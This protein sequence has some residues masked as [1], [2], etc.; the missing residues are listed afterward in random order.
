MKSIKL[1]LLKISLLVILLCGAILTSVFAW[2]SSKQNTISTKINGSIV[3]EYFH[4]GRGT[5]DNPFII[6]RPI[7]YYHMVEF[8]QR[9]TNLDIGDNEKASFGKEYLYFQIGCPLAQLADP[10][11]TNDPVDENDWYV[12]DYSNIGSVNESTG[13]G[14]VVPGTNILASKTLNMAYFSGERALMPIGS[15]QVPFLGSINGH[16][17]TI[18]NLHIVSH[19]IVNVVDEHGVV[20]SNVSR[21]TADMGV[22]GCVAQGLDVNGD[23]KIES[24]LKTDDNGLEED[25]IETSSIKNMYITNATIDLDSTA[26]T[27]EIVGELPTLPDG[28]PTHSNSYHTVDENGEVAETGTE[29]AYVGYIAGHVSSTDDIT[30]V[31]VNNCKIVG[32]SR[33]ISGYGYF[34]IIIDP[35]TNE[36]VSSLGSQIANIYTQ[37]EGSGFGGSIGMTD[38]FER[39]ANIRSMSSNIRNIT[40]E[41]VIVDEVE[42]KTTRIATAYAGADAYNPTD[43]TEKIQ[44]YYSPE[45]GLYYLY[46]RGSMTKGYNYLYG[47][48]N[49]QQTKTVTTITYP[50]D[51][52]TGTYVTTD[53]YKIYEGTSNYLGV[54][55][56]NSFIKTTNSNAVTLAFDNDNHL[57]FIGKDSYEQRYDYPYNENDNG[58]SYVDTIYYL[59]A[60]NNYMS[61]GA[62]TSQNASTW[63]FDTSNRLYT[64]N[65]NTRYYLDY[66]NNQWY[67]TPASSFYLFKDEEG[68]YLSLSG[69]SLTN[70]YSEEEA[71]KFEIVNP[72]SSTTI[73]KIIN[74]SRYY[75]R[76]N[77]GTLD[78]N[79]TA[80]NNTWSYDS[81]NQTYYMTI[82]STRYYLVCYNDNWVLR[83]DGYIYQISDSGNYLNATSTTSF[84]NETDSSLASFWNLDSDAESTTIYT[85]FNGTVTYLGVNNGNLALNPSYSSYNWYRDENAYYTT[86]NGERFYLG[87]EDGVWKIGINGYK[88][89]TGINYLNASSTTSTNNVTSGEENAST[90]IFDPNANTTQFY[91]FY[92]GTKVYLG[93]NGY[94]LTVST[95]PTTWTKEDGR[96]YI[97][98]DGDK[99]YLVFKNNSW[100]LENSG[101]K[102]YSGY[103]YLNASSTTTVSNITTG[104]QNAST[105]IFDP[106]ANSTEI[107]TFSNGTKV[108]LGRNGNSLAVSTTPTTW[109]N[110][111]GKYYITIAGIIFYLTFKN[112]TWVLENN[113]FHI[114]DGSTNYLSASSA[115]QFT[116]SNL[117]N[118]NIWI[119]DNNVSSTTISTVVNGTR[120]YL[121]INGYSLALNSSYSTTLWTKDG[122]D[123]YALSND[124]VKLYLTYTNS[125][126]TVVYDTVKIS[127]GSNYLRAR[128]NYNYPDNQANAAN[129]TNFI[130][131]RN[132]E[133]TTISFLYNNTTRYYLGIDEDTA[134]ILAVGTKYSDVLWKK[135]GNLYYTTYNGIDYYI[136]YSYGNWRV[137]PKEYVRF[138]NN[139]LSMYIYS[140]SRTRNTD[141]PTTTANFYFDSVGRCYGFYS[142]AKYYIRNYNNYVYVTNNIGYAVELVRENNSVYTIVNEKRYYITQNDIQTNNSNSW[143]FVAA[144]TTYAINDGNGN[145]LRVTG[146]GTNSYE[147]VTNFN[148]ATKFTFSGTTSGTISTVINGNTYYLRYNGGAL[149]VS[150]TSTTWNYSDDTIK[151]GNYEIVYDINDNKWKLARNYYVLKSGTSYMGYSGTNTTV[152]NKN[153][154]NILLFTSLPTDEASTLEVTANNNTYY[155]YCEQSNNS[156]VTISNNSRNWTFYD[157]NLYYYRNWR[158]TYYLRIN[159]NNWQVTTSDYNASTI[160]FERYYEYHTYRADYAE[161]PEYAVDYEATYTQTLVDNEATKNADFESYSV[162]NN[163]QTTSYTPTFT[164]SY[165]EYSSIRELFID[166]IM[167]IFSTTQEINL[168]THYSDSKQKTFTVNVESSKLTGFTTY[169]PIRVPMSEE[170]DYDENN[171]YKA[172]L[173]NTGYIIGG[174][175]YF[176]NRQS[177]G[178]IRVSRYEKSNISSYNGNYSTLY[179]FDGTNRQLTAED[180]EKFMS[181]GDKEVT[182][183]DEN[184]NETKETIYGAQTQFDNMIGSYADGLHFMNAQISMNSIITVP[185]ATILNRTYYNYQFPSDCIDFKVLKRGAISFFAG[186]Y[187]S[188]NNAFFSLH[189]IFRDDN[190][191]ITDIKEIQ[192]VYKLKNAALGTADYIYLY[193]D[194]DSDSSNDLYGRINQETQEFEVVTYDQIDNVLTHYEI[195]FN[196]DWITNPTGVSSNDNKVYYFEIP[197]DKGEYA[198]GSVAGKTGA[199][200]LYLDIAANGGDEVG[201]VVSGQGN[202]V[203][204][205]FKV[206]FRSPGS[207]SDFAIMQLFIDCPEEAEASSR[208]VNERLFN[209]Q[210]VFD[211]TETGNG[212]YPKG[213][214]NIYITNKVPNSSVKIDVFLVDNDNDIMTEFPY[215]YRII[216]TNLDYAD[217]RITN[218]ADLD[219]YQA[220]SSFEIPSSGQAIETDYN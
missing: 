181:F 44:Y 86:I 170:S 207:V 20:T 108:Y 184:G 186:E 195:T 27:T 34:G 197:C 138:T 60:T 88:I 66:D 143:G 79:T 75:L 98:I 113:G 164:I 37:G 101:Y 172:S 99:F 70:V 40:G 139:N 49:H 220:V 9:T 133:E 23:G 54:D 48:N 64:T 95:T 178:D 35:T 156:N 82:G 121:G 76:N 65:G 2:F 153:A 97:T 81:S 124:G 94:S 166:E 171:L 77:N 116:N 114:Y 69:T 36:A 183:T 219:Y 83:P 150:T 92:S 161:G 135:D 71:T 87:C 11:N 214:Y 28:T 215:A 208:G 218:V 144:T 89:Y 30:D 50:K 120:T 45:V 12:F 126:W 206:D 194:D 177:V 160:E 51:P 47:E 3:F 125:T 8:F 41:T 201:S 203:S 39:L 212:I 118:A 149:Q 46:F 63:A 205:S 169:M 122:N 21:S 57:Y 80:S 72:G 180:L 93:R 193:K 188:G 157:N 211:D 32:G 6:T 191:N 204:T 1:N 110:D 96:Y 16:M 78:F 84:N 38:L 209:V 104:A 165:S 25:L 61:I 7:H 147:N 163:Y 151:Y 62:T 18:D 5:K 42:G 22:F 10:T 174:G 142:N 158:N 13:S 15:S 111:N 141:N 200:L 127:N 198:L 173:K 202:D 109:T 213:I 102:F 106:E 155:L 112:N 210:V 123:Y 179:T 59:N 168:D 190:Q 33:S 67:L 146:T 130:I 29:V 182:V 162:N 73:S 154:S 14:T 43:S 216:Y 52:E 53:G 17:M 4:A 55:L 137:L 217:L 105:W 175:N 31:Y 187:F 159:G 131:D 189:Q 91:T 134:Q 19:S 199:Y 185:Q 68:N 100:I 196:T 129:G 117:N 58:T 148:D 107:Y 24:I 192:Y 128:Y 90:W 85:I 152:V 132:A 167:I 136:N 119:L 140:T 74:G 115:T 56:D 26:S 103:N 176:V 145:Y